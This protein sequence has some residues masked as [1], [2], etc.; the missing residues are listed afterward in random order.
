M[1][2]ELKLIIERDEDLIPIYKVEDANNLYLVTKNRS[3]ADKVY[4]ELKLEYKKEQ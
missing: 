4:K 3:V 1:K 2:N